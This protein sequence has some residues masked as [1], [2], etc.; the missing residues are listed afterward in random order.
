MRLISSASHLSF[1]PF[2][3]HTIVFESF[4]GRQISDS[5]LVVYQDI[6]TRYPDVS[7][8]WS[9]GRSS[10]LQSYCDRN[11]IPYV[12]RE[13]F[14]WV[15][16]LEKSDVWVSNARFPAWLNKPKRVQFIQTWH[17]TPLKKLGLSI[18]RVEMPGTSTELYHSNFVHEAN[19]WDLLVSANKY[20]SNIFRKSFGYENEIFE[21]GYPR[22]DELI[23]AS[24][25][26]IEQ[27]KTKLKI[28]KNKKVILYAPTFRDDQFYKI[29][30]YK[31]SLPF[32]LDDFEKQFGMN[33]VLILRMHYLIANEIDVSKYKNVVFDFSNYSNVSDLYLVS[34]MLITDYSSVFFDYAYLKRP[35]LFYPFDFDNYKDKLRGFYLD[36]QSDLPGEIAYNQNELFNLI[37]ETLTNNSTPLSLKFKTFY[38]QFCYIHEGN[39]GKLLA[40]RIMDK[41]YKKN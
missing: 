25:K 3:E 22:N 2:R 13:S 40:D 28:P 20:S 32:K 14:S 4:G 12:I 10:E 34:D 19:R 38:Q 21:I 6:K 39:S 1:K 9:I 31:F 37:S 30:K 24:Q 33:T 35:I 8:Y 18:E 29:G 15:K 27:L 11:N 36:Y 5:P 23:N 41:K 7:C 17:G 16:V 26:D